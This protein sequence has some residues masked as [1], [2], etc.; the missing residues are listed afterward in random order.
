ME[1]GAKINIWS[2]LLILTFTKK[3]WD[4]KKKEGTIFSYL[5]LISSINRC[6]TL[7]EPEMDFNAALITKNFNKN[8]FTPT[9]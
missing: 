2:T 9:K 3:K 5:G 6:L 8:T 4:L 7:L 1:S